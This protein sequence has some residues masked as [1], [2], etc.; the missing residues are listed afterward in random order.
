MS[1]ITQHSFAKLRRLIWYLKGE[2]RWIQVFKFGDMSSE[3]TVFSSRDKETRK[4]S[5][6]GVALVGRHLLKAFSRKQKIITRSSVEAELFAA[7]LGASEA[8]SVE[9]MMSDLGFVVKPVL[10]FGAKESN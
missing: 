6:A 4:S 10:I 9:N 7:A 3:V 2:R 8:K 1:D 5:S